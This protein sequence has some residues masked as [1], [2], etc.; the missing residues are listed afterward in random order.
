MAAG[1]YNRHMDTARIARLLRETCLL[2]PADD[3]VV[4]VSGGADSLTLLEV[5]LDLGYHPLVGHLDHRLRPS[6]RQEAELVSSIAAGKGLG[7]AVESIDVN[8]IRPGKSPVD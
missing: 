5:L 8:C 2:N 7:W 1:R 6:S 4:G 3:M